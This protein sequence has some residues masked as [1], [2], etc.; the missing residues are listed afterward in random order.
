MGKINCRVH[1]TIAIAIPVRDRP[2]ADGHPTATTPTAAPV[3]AQQ[4]T[5]PA[6]QPPSLSLVHVDA[7]ASFAAAPLSAHRCSHGIG[8]REARVDVT[9]TH[10]LLCLLA[11]DAGEWKQGW[12]TGGPANRYAR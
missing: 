6:A 5:K 8:V 2:A 7:G 1:T 3:A 9:V 12:S 11:T 10:F 4:P